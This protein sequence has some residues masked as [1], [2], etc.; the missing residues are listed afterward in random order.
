MEAIREVVTTIVIILVLASLLEMI[1][2]NSNMQRF[3]KVIMGLFI[4]VTLLN[5]IV[6]LIHK[7]LGD[8]LVN[9]QVVE[10]DPELQSIL[11]NGKALGEQSKEKAILEYEK[12]LSQQI[13]SLTR[14]ADNSPIQEAE[15]KVSRNSEGGIGKIQEV[16]LLIGDG[17]GDKVNNNKSSIEPVN[18]VRVDISNSSQKSQAR[19]PTKEVLASKNAELAKAVDVVLNFYGLEQEQVKLQQLEVK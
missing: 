9:W 2:P 11:A 6:G 15:V 4:I 18:P 1:L 5:P 12:R 3:V 14:L 19:D 16:I 8:E 17:Q 7:D 10:D 13:L